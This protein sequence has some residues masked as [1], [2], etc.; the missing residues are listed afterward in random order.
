MD[1]ITQYQQ[2]ITQL[3][4]EYAAIPPS[5]PTKLRDEVVADTVRN[6]FQLVS[7]GWEENKFIHEVIFHL[8]IIEGKIWVQRNNTEA[9]L[10]GELTDRGIPKSDIVIGFQS[11]AIR[12]QTGYAVA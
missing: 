3:L 1:K 8:D 4:E 2:I 10:S 6:H 5:Y 11:P 9:D 7:L 12:S